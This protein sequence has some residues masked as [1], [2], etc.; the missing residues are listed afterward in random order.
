RESART[1]MTKIIPRILLT[2]ATGLLGRY[3]LRDLLLEGERVAVLA[4][5]SRSM[6]AVERIAEIVAFWS[7][8]LGRRLPQP[9]VVTGDVRSNHLGLAE[10]DLARL[11]DCELVL[12]SAAS[13]TF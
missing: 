8:H 12:H 10:S 1:W 4:R 11:A 5:D 9:L 3:L 2:G 13:L 6:S 7:E